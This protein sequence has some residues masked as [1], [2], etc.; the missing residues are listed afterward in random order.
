MKRLIIA[1]V[2]F[3]AALPAWAQS[4]LYQKYANIEGITKV[5]VSPTLL[6]LF[7]DSESGQMN[8]LND[9]PVDISKISQKLTG[10]YIL[11]T[12]DPKVGASMTDD[13]A[14]YIQKG[15]YEVL[16]EAVDGDEKCVMYVHK[17]NDLIKEFC[18][19]AFD[20][21]ECTLIIMTGNLTSQDIADVAV[22]AQ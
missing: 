5:Y 15:T 19:N 2:L 18:I 10:I 12:E 21:S 14:M 6:S 20:G 3:C 9:A 16:M 8:M 7:S 11:S 4:E 22:M 1:I 17:E 13:F